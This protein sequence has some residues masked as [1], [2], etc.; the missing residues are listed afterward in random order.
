M[1]TVHAA[2][3]LVLLL[4]TISLV[5]TFTIPT[6]TTVIRITTTTKDKSVAKNVPNTRRMMMMMMPIDIDVAV[7]LS[8]TVPESIMA[9]TSTIVASALSQVTVSDSDAVVT[10]SSS[11][12]SQL[13]YF[14][15]L[16]LY[17]LSF[18]GLISIIQ[19]STSA[20]MKRK[21]YVSPGVNYS[22]R[23]ASSADTTAADTDTDTTTMI[24][25]EKTPISLRDQAIEI[26]A[27]MKGN[28]YAVQEMT[29][30]TITF[31]G[32]VQR[33]L[34][35]AFFLTFCTVLGLLSLALV[36]QIQFQ[37]MMEEN[38]I[39]FF[40][41]ALLSPYAGIYYWNAG[42]RVDTIQIQLSTNTDETINDITMYGPDDEMERMWRTLQL[43]EKNMI[44]ISSILSTSSSAS[45]P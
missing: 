30:T 38:D 19:R 5:H 1:A 33:S 2:I 18:P 43:Q 22:N 14:T 8:S 11:S 37:S 28:N 23:T 15:V 44:P 45:T 32:T 34:S 13:S 40:Y 36:L 26:M 21:T 29:N 17:L 25:M 35:Q 39:N 4:N 41:L 20:K 24:M 9:S 10:S 6:T 3:V 42:D 12:Y 16:G 7:L 31:A 27:Y